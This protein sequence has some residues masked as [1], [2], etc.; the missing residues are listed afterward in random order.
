MEEVC[1]FAALML[2]MVVQSRECMGKRRKIEDG[3]EEQEELDTLLFVCTVDEVWLEVMDRR[4]DGYDSDTHKQT[5][6]DR[7]SVVG[8]AVTGRSRRID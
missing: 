7:K 5:S 6:L 1:E 8:H 4:I 2:E 3:G